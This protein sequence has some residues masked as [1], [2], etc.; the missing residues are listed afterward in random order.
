MSN[1]SKVLMF[2]LIV[3]LF[4]FSQNQ[5]QPDTLWK[6]SGNVTLNFSQVSLTNWAAGGSSSGSGVLMIKL[7]G[8]YKKEKVSWDNSADLRLGFLKEGDQDMRKSDDMIDLN[9][10]LGI[11]AKEHWYYSFVLGFKSQFAEG[12]NYPDT[13]NLIS[14][15]MAPGYLNTGLGMDYKT[16]KLSILMAPLSGKFTFV[17]DDKLSDDG[18]FGVDPG[19]KSRAELGATV[20]MEY[21]TPLVKNVDLETNLDLFS[22]YLDKPQNIDVDWKVL[23]NMKINDWL[24]ANL[25]TRLIYDDDILIDIDD[26][27]DGEPD[28]KGRRVQF[29]EMFGAG[30]SIKF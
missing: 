30:I 22:S 4:S 21:K 5:S 2:F 27:D 1:F 20:K 9:S 8:N 26:N 11:E 10:K 13:E 24:S 16:E 25:A 19:K 12:Y 28:R 17:M 7:A 18:A 23:I 14:K 3:P 15:F 6:T 29:M